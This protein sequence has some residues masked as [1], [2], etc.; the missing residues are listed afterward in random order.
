MN[1]CTAP[2]RKFFAGITVAL[3]LALSGCGGGGGESASVVTP[4]P[5]VPVP[6]VGTLSL[7]A[8]GTD[9][10]NV[11]GT[12]SVA[13]FSNPS[14]L[15]I[16]AVGNLYV[17][18]QK[19]NAI[20]RVTPGGIVSTFASNVGTRE[21]L[22]DTGSV[23]RYSD[24][25]FEL[26]VDRLGNVVVTDGNSHLASL[27]L[28][29]GSKHV[30]TGSQWPNGSFAG[31]VGFT[32]RSSPRSVTSDSTGNFYTLDKSLVRKFSL[33]GA[34]SMLTCVTGIGCPDNST[35]GGI[36]TDAIGNIFVAYHNTVSKITPGGVATALTGS[37]SETGFTDGTG[38][39]ARFNLPSAL[40][41]DAAGNI[42][43][44]DTSNN[45]VRKITPA[46]VVTTIAGKPGASG[47]QP[48]PLPASLTLPRGIAV[49]TDGTIYV[50]SENAILKIQ[51]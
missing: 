43:V 22:T 9:S 38:A 27:V 13:R 1:T 47:V 15:G 7:L 26:T 14:A 29:D 30:V 36:T 37:S 28:P 48:G 42:L 31:F 10:G 6:V 18:D 19:N 21:A 44:A 23:F 33:A 12:G 20:R 51:P 17:A 49:H 50:T 24:F 35:D 11:D 41:T 16:D 46:G 25:R 45:A 3:L 34:D 4:P 32:G 2:P 40:A 8:G 39:A 5:P